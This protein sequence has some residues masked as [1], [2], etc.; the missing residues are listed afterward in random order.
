M[1]I[2]KARH[3]L[4]ATAVLALTSAAMLVAP[5]VSNA[6]V[7]CP[8]GGTPVTKTVSV[9]TLKISGSQKTQNLAA[10]STFTIATSQT[11]PVTLSLVSYT[12]P[13]PSLTVT[14]P[15]MIHSWQTITLN[16]GASGMMK[17]SLPQCGAYQVDLVVGRP[18]PFIMNAS[19]G[20]AA[21]GRLLGANIGPGTANEVACKPTCHKPPCHKPC[22]PPPCHHSLA[23][24]P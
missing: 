18:L 2:L 19:M 5:A 17:V 14:Y 15:Q 10:T 6:A 4:A 11:A 24:K 3:G 20:Y 21:A 8:R 12:R 16:P 9:C 22:P 7:K 1:N 23:R 13:D